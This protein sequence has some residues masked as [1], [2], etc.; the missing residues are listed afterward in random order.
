LLTKEAKQKNMV[1]MKLEVLPHMGD[2]GNFHTFK[3]YS[4]FPL[5]KFKENV[6]LFG[7]Q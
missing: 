4:D 3:N 6:L 2:S 1:E 5:K 7:G